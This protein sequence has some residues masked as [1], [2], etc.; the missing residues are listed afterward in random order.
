MNELQELYQQVIIDHNKNPK[1]FGTLEHAT[2][3]AEGYNPLC[4]DKVNIY[5]QIENDRVKDIR[6]NGKGCAISK[7][8]CFYYDDIIER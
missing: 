5:L 6:F 7:S 2:H 3:V 4:G 8:V 1:N